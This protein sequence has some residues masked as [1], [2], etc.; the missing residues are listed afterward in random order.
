M[1]IALECA[2]LK[3]LVFK[4]YIDETFVVW[5]HA[6]G[7]LEQLFLVF[8]NSIHPNIEFPMEVEPHGMLPFLNVLIYRKDDGSGGHRVYTKPTDVDLCE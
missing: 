8:L 2:R 3:P 7:K 5:A 4:H 6:K 1:N